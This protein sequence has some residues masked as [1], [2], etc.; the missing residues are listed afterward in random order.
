M[1]T[2]TPS[3]NDLN[4]CGGT[5]IRPDLTRA[6]PSEQGPVMVDES[7]HGMT[8]RRFLGAITRAVAALIATAYS[9]PAIAFILGPSLQSRQELWVRLG[10]TRKIALDTPTLFKATVDRST[11]WVS[12]TA[13]VS[14][15]ILTRDGREFIAMSNVCT[16]LGCRVRWIHDQR[17]FFCPCH[18]GVFDEQG[19]VVSG[20]PPRPLDRF[21]VK[22][23]GS[24]IFILGS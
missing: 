17:L 22:V 9:I 19:N 5:H 2:Q 10:S 18:N 12:T 16:H 14:V 1:E 21:P 4:R 20:P 24:D 7:P 11:G 3:E 23:E 15:Y 8:R 13:D 6:T